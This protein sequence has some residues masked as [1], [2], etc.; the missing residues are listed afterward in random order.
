MKESKVIWYWCTKLCVAS[1][2]VGYT[3]NWFVAPCQYYINDPNI[4]EKFKFLPVGI[5]LLKVNNKNIRTKC[6]ICSKL[7]IKIPE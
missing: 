6:E 3:R 7:T 1:G 2:N 5:N 4:I